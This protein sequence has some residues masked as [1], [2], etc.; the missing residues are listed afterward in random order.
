LTELNGGDDGAYFICNR[1]SNHQ[2]N[3]FTVSAEPV[4]GVVSS[5]SLLLNKG[6]SEKF[7]NLS[8]IQL[9]WQPALT[10]LNGG[11]DGAYFLCTGLSNHQGNSFTVSAE[12]V[13]GVVSIQSL[14]LNKGPIEKFLNL[15]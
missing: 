12:P 15:S 2:G 11:D 6:P 10:E 9:A 13:L 5:Q 14:L 4:L 7:L 3:P 8:F 1:L